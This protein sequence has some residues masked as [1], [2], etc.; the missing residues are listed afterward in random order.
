LEDVRYVVLVG[1]AVSGEPLAG[2]EEGFRIERGPQ[3][4]QD[5]GLFLVGVVPPPV[6]GAR[7]DDRF[8]SLPEPS[9]LVADLDAQGAG[10]SLEV[11]LLSGWTCSGLP[12]RGETK[13]SR[14]SSSPSVSWAVLR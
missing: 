13:R 14:L 6:R 3:F 2:L 7:W 4:G 1:L 12:P 8:L 9:V 11:F 10:Y 5:V